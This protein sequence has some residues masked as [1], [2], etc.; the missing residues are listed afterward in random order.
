[1]GDRLGT[2]GAVGFLVFFSHFMDQLYVR[3]SNVNS[4]K[5]V[6]TQNKVFLPLFPAYVGLPD[7]HIG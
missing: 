1:M 2:L 4:K 7:D 5:G 3:L 6:K